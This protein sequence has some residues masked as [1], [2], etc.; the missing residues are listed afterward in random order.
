MFVVDIVHDAVD[1][2]DMRA[3]NRK[4]CWATL[5]RCFGKNVMFFQCGIDHIECYPIYDV[6][7]DPLFSSCTFGFEFSGSVLS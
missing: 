1:E 4:E 3:V 6:I 7:V 2:R 5:F